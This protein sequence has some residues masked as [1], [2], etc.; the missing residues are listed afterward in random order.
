MKKIKYSEITPEKIY[1]RRR[2]FIKRFGITTGSLIIGQNIINTANAST[3]NLEKK[4]TEYRYITTYNNYYEFGTRKSDPVE[5]SQNFK[6]KP[7]EITIDGEVEKKI[8]LTIQEIK[9]MFPSE[10]RIYRL[11]CVE[12]WSMVIPWLGFSLS[13]ILEK[14]S[15]TSKGKFVEFTSVYDPEQM[16]GQRYP[17][18]KWPYKEGLRIDEAMH[19][20]TTLVTGLYNKELPNQNGAPLRLIIPWKY[21]FKS[22]KAIVNIKLVEKMPTS[23]WMRASPKEYGFYSNVNPNV[24]HPRWSQASERVVGSGILSERIPTQM[25]NGYGDEVAN[26]YSGMDLKKYF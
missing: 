7:W 11:R 1:N 13:K 10:E 15:P 18:L 9:N 17:I 26:L 14:A 19:P 16:P 23:S 3:N 25:F 20:L 12:G 5:K 8:T 24:D 4:I 21:G 6:T 2:E 22:T